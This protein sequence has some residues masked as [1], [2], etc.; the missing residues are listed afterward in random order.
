MRPL[1]KA[2]WWVVVRQWV[3]SRALCMTP[4]PMFHPLLTNSYVSP[5]P[6]LYPLPLCV[7]ASRCMVE[8]DQSSKPHPFTRLPFLRFHPLLTTSDTFTCL[9]LCPLP[10]CQGFALHGR[11]GAIS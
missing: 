2:M 10:L 5:P 6:A 1:Q 3:V 8:G 7:R 9:P 11:R 4:Y